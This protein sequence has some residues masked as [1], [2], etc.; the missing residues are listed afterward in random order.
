MAQLKIQ[1]LA[2]EHATDL[3]RT[4]RGKISP[5]KQILLE[6]R[7]H[8]EY[9]CDAYHHDPANRAPAA[10][11]KEDVEADEGDENLIRDFGGGRD[12]HDCNDKLAHTHP[13]GAKQQDWT[14][15]PFLNQI[16]TGQ[17]REHIDK[18]GSEAN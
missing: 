11:E 13:D 8:G 18:I 12:T 7:S 1:L 9:R 4:R 16:K 5:C 14:T 2:I 17:S 10:G 6:R 3:A 15:T